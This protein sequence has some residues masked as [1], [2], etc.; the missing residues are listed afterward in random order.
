VRIDLIKTILIGS[1]AERKSFYKL[2]STPCP[3][4]LIET[5]SIAPFRSRPALA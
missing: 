2:F 3:V 1:T 5:G 4:A